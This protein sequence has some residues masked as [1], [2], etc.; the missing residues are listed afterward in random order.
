MTFKSFKTHPTKSVHATLNVPKFY[1]LHFF[2]LTVMLFVILH[3]EV[4]TLCS[5]SI[6]T[7]PVYNGAFLGPGLVNLTCS[8]ENYLKWNIYFLFFHPL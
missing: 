5:K 2:S 4:E 3:H 7:Q 8:G 1:N 6:R